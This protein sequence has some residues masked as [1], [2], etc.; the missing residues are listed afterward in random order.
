[1]SKFFISNQLTGMKCREKSF[2]TD[3]RQKSLIPKET[4]TV[5]NQK[6]NTKCYVCW[7]FEK[8]N[9]RVVRAVRA[10]LHVDDSRDEEEQED[11]G[12]Q[13]GGLM[14]DGQQRVEMDR[15]LSLSAPVP[16]QTERRDMLT[17][18]IGDWKVCFFTIKDVGAV[19]SL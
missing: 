7:V 5:K 8:L 13:H 16:L 6:S 15:I 3:K 2:L 1:M 11:H 18:V 17:S 12:K 14:V 4:Y 9:L 19:M 10:A